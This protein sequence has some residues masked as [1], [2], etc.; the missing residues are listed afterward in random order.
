MRA[1][2]P[3]AVPVQ[4]ATQPPVFESGLPQTAP[5]RPVTPTFS[6]CIVVRDRPVLLVKA[7][8]SV[9]A[10]HFT[11]FEV[12]IV[13]DGSQIP[14][15]E[16]LS[17]AG[18]LYDGRIRVIRQPPTGIAPARNAG[19]RAAAGR[20][21]TVLDSDDELSPDALMKLERLIASTGTNW[22][23]ADY[24]ELYSNGSRKRIRLPEYRS[25]QGMLMGVLTRPR[26]PFKHSGTTVERALLERIGHYDESLRIFEDIELML[27][28]LRSGVRPQHLAHPI[29]SFRRHDGNVTR[30]RLDG[31]GI[32]FSLIE[33]YRPRRRPGLGLM[34]KGLRAMSE[35]GKWLVSIGR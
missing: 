16:V 31:L 22:I 26:L 13:D 23:Y 1:S 35:I 30:G 2:A 7:V 4:R 27:R 9:L 10:N 14:V 32:W 29:I 12:M 19:L 34:I 18:V 25:S 20:Y 17:K 5:T 3:A 6:V 8:E 28:A 33:T 11:D 24:E 15:T 21:I